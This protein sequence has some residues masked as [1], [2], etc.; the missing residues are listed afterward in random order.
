MPF[1]PRSIVHQN[2]PALGAA[3]CTPSDTVDCPAFLGQPP[4]GVFIGAAG[5]L[6]VIF[7]NDDT[8]TPITFPGLPAASQW[9][10]AVKR[11]MSTNTTASSIR[12]LY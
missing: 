7:L 11:V 1:L 6:A 5:D 2:D 12:L 4:R 9:P 3:N 10:W 8:N